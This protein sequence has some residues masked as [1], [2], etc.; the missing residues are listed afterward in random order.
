MNFD[1]YLELP[2]HKRAELILSPIDNLLKTP[3]WMERLNTALVS[4]SPLVV[5]FDKGL[6]NEYWNLINFKNH[7]KCHN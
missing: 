3:F 2:T 4:G 6:I 7:S 5:S 1:T